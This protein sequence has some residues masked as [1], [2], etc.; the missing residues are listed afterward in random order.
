[1]NAKQRYEEKKNRRAAKKR[2]KDKPDKLHLKFKQPELEGKLISEQCTQL[3]WHSYVYMQTDNL[4]FL[5]VA[6]CLIDDGPSIGFLDLDREAIEN[7]GV[8]KKAESLDERKELNRV[9]R[10]LYEEGNIAG[11][12]GIRCNEISCECC[13]KKYDAMEEMMMSQS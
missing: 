3:G 13:I 2:K 7:L 9:L 8:L 1:M 12:T 6:R 5:D 10:N 4:Y 11:T